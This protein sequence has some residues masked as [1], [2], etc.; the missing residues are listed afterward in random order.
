MTPTPYVL[1]KT[2]GSNYMMTFSV[3]ISCFNSALSLWHI[4]R[5]TY[6]AGL[7]DGRYSCLIVD[8]RGIWYNNWMIYPTSKFSRNIVNSCSL[9]SVLLVFPRNKKPQINLESCLQPGI[10]EWHMNNTW[11]THFLS[12]FMSYH[13]SHWEIMLVGQCALLSF[14]FHS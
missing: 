4:Q 8:F 9:F 11:I 6:N 13:K 10:T 3:F 2:W 5:H 14:N 12:H 1:N 7:R